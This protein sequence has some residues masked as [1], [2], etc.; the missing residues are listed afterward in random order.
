[1][2]AGGP[3]VC[4]AGTP[5]SGKST[6]GVALAARLGAIVLDMDTA[7]NPLIGEIAELIGAG[8]DL[9]HPGLGGAVR[10]A[11][12]RCVVDVAVENVALGRAAV[13]IA[14]F[15][16]EVTDQTQWAALARRFAPA[17]L[18]LVWVD[19]PAEVAWERRRRRGHARDRAAMVKGDAPRPSGPGVPHILADGAA[20][21]TSEIDRVVRALGLDPRT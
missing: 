15:T 14:P 1:M 12:Y 6:L 11:R 13:M 18:W 2:T 20:D 4:V 5:G 17:D 7:T 10:A 16:A 8:D 3:A 19:V 21:V 9:D